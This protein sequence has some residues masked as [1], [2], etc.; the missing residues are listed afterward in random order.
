MTTTEAAERPIARGAWYA[1]AVLTLVYVFNAV[2]RSVM[3]IV[4][5]PVRHEFG[6]NDSQLGLLTGLAFGLTY[7]IAGIPIGMLV[8]RVNRRNL[9]SV[10]LF[11]WSGATAL[12]G[13]ATGYVSLVVSRLAVGAAESAGAPT[14]LSM[15]ADLFPKSRRSTPIGI[16]WVSTALGTAISLVI[17]GVIAT[18]YGWRAAFFIA[19]VPGILL[20]FLLFF[21][22]KEPVREVDEK[23]AQLKAPSYFSTLAYIFRTPTVRH[24]FLGIALNSI[25]MS[26]VPVWAASFLIRTQD[27]SLAQAGLFAGIGVGVFGGIGSL[28][29]GPIGDIVTRRFGLPALA[30]VPMVMSAASFFSGLV[31]ALSGNLVMVAI[32]F[33][34]FEIFSRAHTASAYA[35]LLGGVES[36]M[37]GVVVSSVQAATNLIG[38]GVGPLIVGVVSQMVGGGSNSLQFGMTAVMFAMLWAAGHFALAWRA[39]RRDGV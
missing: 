21:T 23:G 20:A 30:S 19:G 33:I 38:Y 7:A 26:G 29:G 13:L 22:V 14:A 4:I 11:A 18:N 1:L 37:R 2:D 5:E 3:S 17:G 16:F 9:L 15:I 27:F 12:C 32:G 8:D 34:L 10:M 24:P 6:L 25:A 39:A 28:I 36:R 35:L 31:F